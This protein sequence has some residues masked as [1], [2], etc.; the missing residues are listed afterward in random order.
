MSR[1]G[2][3]SWVGTHGGGTG[4]VHV[5][6]EQTIE[7]TVY[8]GTP[9]GNL[10]IKRPREKHAYCLHLFPDRYTKPSRTSR[11]LNTP[12]VGVY[13]PGSNLF[14]MFLGYDADTEIDLYKLRTVIAYLSLIHI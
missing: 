13:C 6:K 1:A 3:G 4:R 10:C 8:Y 9:P 5:D 14:C 7:P 2:I 11:T 12:M